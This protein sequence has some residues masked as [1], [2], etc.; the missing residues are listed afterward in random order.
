MEKRFFFVLLPICIALVLSSVPFAYSAAT[1]TC[2]NCNSGT[3][4][5][6]TS[7]S[8]GYADYFGSSNPSCSGLPS[9]ENSFSG[10]AFSFAISGTT[11]FQVF[12]NDGNTSSCKQQTY[13]PATTSTT[14]TTTT[15]PIPTPTMSCTGCGSG[16]CVCSISCNSGTLDYFSSSAC[17]AVPILERTF[18]GGSSSFQITSTA[19]V[20]AYCDTGVSTSCSTLTYAPTQTS[21]TSTSTSSTTTT[22]QPATTFSCTGCNTGNCVCTTS[23]S[24]GS[25]NYFSTSACSSVPTKQ[26]TF[27]GGSLSLTVTQPTYVQIYCDDGSLGSCTTLTNSQSATTTTTSTTST[28]TTTLAPQIPVISCSNC[29]SGNCTCSVTICDTGNLDYYNN[30]NCNAI[31]YKESTFTSGGFNI[32]YYNSSFYIETFCDNGNVSAC[33]SIT[34]FVSTSTTTTTTNANC[35]QTGSYCNFTSDCCIGNI[36]R[37]GVC[38]NTAPTTSTTTSVGGYNPGSK[39]FCPFECCSG[40]QNYFDKTCLNGNECNNHLCETTTSTTTE[41]GLISAGGYQI[42]FSLLIVTVF[43]IGIIMM[44]LYYYFGH[45]LGSTAERSYKKI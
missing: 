15:T 45:V 38:A 35:A 31:P 4:S 7:C 18:T 25:L 26:K 13:T 11:Y 19:Y 39:T 44:L 8:T 23:C 17:N 34:S 14:S 27:T 9:V 12:C 10:G 2:T 40:D 29:L 22:T 24:T 16:N 5:C 1:V 37:D 21:T 28:T 33:T 42:S 30:S 6:T 32:S 3:C 36:C 41:S 20:K 43:A